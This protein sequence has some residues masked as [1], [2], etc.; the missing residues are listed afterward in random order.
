[1]DISLRNGYFNV[2]AFLLQRAARSL[3]ADFGLG[4]YLVLA[5]VDRTAAVA[6]CVIIFASSLYANMGAWQIICMATTVRARI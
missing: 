5:P 1:M 2:S 4:L 3:V 6:V